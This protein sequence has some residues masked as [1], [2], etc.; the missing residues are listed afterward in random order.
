M[1]TTGGGTGNLEFDW[2]NDGTGDYDDSE[3][4]SDLAPGDYT[5]CA[6]DEND[7]E[8]CV[9]FT[10]KW[11]EVIPMLDDPG[12][13]NGFG[14]SCA[15]ECDGVISGIVNGN[16]PI[17]VQ[18]D[19]QPTSLPITNLCAGT[20][21]VS[22]LDNEGL[23]AS[24]EVEITEPEAL[25]VVQD[26]TFAACSN[27]SDGVVAVSASGGVGAYDY[28]WNVPGGGA[29]L[30]DLEPGEYTVVVTDDN[31]CQ[32]ML[33]NLEVDD[34]IDAP[35]YDSR[36]VMTPNGD[37]LN[38]DLFI[39]CAD[40][41]PSDLEVYDRWG[42]RVYAQTMYDNSWTGLNLAGNE[43]PEGAYMWVLRVTLGSGERQ[44]YKGTVTIL[45]DQF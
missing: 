1:V 13:Y 4:I 35:C 6:R 24:V 23:T 43:L 34:C 12:Q 9:S 18:I 31:N 5:L 30:S 7:C 8:K 16:E 3:D 27:G 37:N 45:R 29:I 42:K 40:D 28:E 25:T 2:D 33:Q 26:S 17:Q 14:V 41:N 36:T 22:F 39:N 11:A 44:I 21:I 15:G 19:N 20:Y 38:E 10:V 32:V